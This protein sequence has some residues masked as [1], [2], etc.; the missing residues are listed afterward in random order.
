[1][2]NLLF[3]LIIATTAVVFRSGTFIVYEGSQVVITQ[4]GKLIGETYE[5]PG[6]YFRVPLIQRAHYFDARIQTWEGHVNYVP[7][8]DKL[9]V[10][11]EAVGHWRINDPQKF[12]ETLGTAE[13]ARSRLD[14]ILNDAVKDMVSS[15]PLVDTVRNTNRVLELRTDFEKSARAPVKIS[16]ASQVTDDVVAELESVTIGREHLTRKMLD[17]AAPTLEPLGIEVLNVLIKKV[18]YEPAVEQMVY[19]RMVSERN[20]VAER[21]RSI[22][23]SEQERIRGLTTRDAQEIISPAVRE[24][25]TIKGAADADAVRIY[26][27]SFGKDADFY[28][29]WRSL[30]AYRNA[31]PEKTEMVGA[32]DS[33]FFRVL[34]QRHEKQAAA[35]PAAVPEPAPILAP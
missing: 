23:R 12:I 28:N 2:W 35:S 19:E 6:M 17:S 27:E 30:L 5:T 1:M 4:F 33:D 26:A 3:F 7:T 15:H 18:S 13:A 9:Y 8:K 32:M 31:L 14:S 25:E 10:A 22:G 11:V 24:A 29:F 34:N 20:R 16:K 21:L